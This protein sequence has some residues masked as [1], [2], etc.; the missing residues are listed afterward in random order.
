[1]FGKLI[2][3][4][5]RKHKRGKPVNV[6]ASKALATL[7][8]TV[9]YQCPRCKAVWARKGKKVPVVAAAAPERK[10]A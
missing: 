10:T 5:T 8:G 2:C 4:I 1:M 9:H 6:A 7:P 3:F